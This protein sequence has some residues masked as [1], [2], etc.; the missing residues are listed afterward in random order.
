MGG[1]L[2]PCCIQSKVQDK[3]EGSSG[4][5]LGELAGTAEPGRALGPALLPRGTREGSGAGTAPH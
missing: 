4:A 5:A 1:I 2:T 3:F